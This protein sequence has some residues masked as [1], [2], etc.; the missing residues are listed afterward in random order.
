MK[1]EDA[2]IAIAT[3]E[4]APRRQRWNALHDMVVSAIAARPDSEAA[5][6]TAALRGAGY[7]AAADAH[8]NTRWE[9]RFERRRRFIVAFRSAGDPAQHQVGV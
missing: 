6:V 1:F 3:L 2:A 5:A 8:E 4:R 7:A 9:A